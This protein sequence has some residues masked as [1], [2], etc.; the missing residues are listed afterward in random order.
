M[1]EL[2]RFR[3]AR[4]PQKIGTEPTS[5]IEIGQDSP[6]NTWL[7]ADDLPTVANGYLTQNDLAPPATTLTINNEPEISTILGK[8]RTLDQFLSQHSNRPTVTA[9][10]SELAKLKLDEGLRYQLPNEITS[11]YDENEFKNAV[12][13]DL[14]TIN[15]NDKYN[16]LKPNQLVK[17]TH[18]SSEVIFGSPEAEDTTSVLWL[19]D[20]IS[21]NNLQVPHYLEGVF[22]APV[23]AFCLWLKDEGEGTSS[24]K[25]EVYD[26]SDTLISTLSTQ[27]IHLWDFEPSTSQ[28][29]SFLG[30]LSRK[31]IKSFIIKSGFSLKLNSNGKI[32]ELSPLVPNR[33]FVD[34]FR[35]NKPIPIT[36]NFFDEMR[37]RLGTALVA[38]VLGNATPELRVDLTRLMLVVGLI[39]LSS[40]T[41]LA[42]PDDIYWA[43]RWRSII[44][45]K[46]FL[47]KVRSQRSILARRAGFSDLYIVRDEWN[48][49]EAGEIA[50]IENV[51]AKESKERK[52]VRVD[53][54]EEMFVTDTEKSTLNELDSQTTNRFELSDEA[55]QDVSLAAHIEGKV[56]TSGQYG[57]THV[58]TQLGG[59]LDY[60]TEQSEK[61]ATKLAQETIA[62]AVTRVEEK[63]RETRSRRTLTRIEETNTHSLKNDTD[64]HI[65]G[66]Y[67]WVDKIQR[68]QIFRYPNRYLLEFEVP[69]PGAWIRWLIKINKNKGLLNQEP[70]PFNL[71][72]TQGKLLK[73]SD[74]KVENYLE[75][76]ARYGTLGLTPPPSDEVVSTGFTKASL[77]DNANYKKIPNIGFETINTMTVST[78]YEAKTWEAFIHSWQHD[79]ALGPGGGGSVRISVGTGELKEKAIGVITDENNGSIDKIISGD[80]G[81]I[82]RGV[83]PVSLMTDSIYGFS[84]NVN[85]TCTPLVQTMDKW[86]IDNY[87]KIVSTFNELKLRYDE[88]VAAKSVREGILISGDSSARNKEIIHEELKKQ[89]IEMLIGLDFK[90]RNALSVK[91]NNGNPI[92]PE[93]QLKEAKK[94]APEIQF[95]EQA[96]E[97]ENL[98]YVLYPY[99]W[100]DH[101]RWS[102]LADIN[103]ADPEFVRFL[104]SGSV[105]VIL[106]ARP[107]FEAQ[108]QIYTDFG[109]LWGGGPVPAPGEEGY[110]S[111]A[112]EIKAQTQPP[113]DGIPGESWEVRLPTSLIWLENPVGLPKNPAPKLSPPFGENKGCICYIIKPGDTLS[114]I[115]LRFYGN[116]EEYMKIFEANRDVIGDDPD[117]IYAGQVITIPR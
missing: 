64:R 74:L 10:K 60:S 41:K 31:P 66:V 91:D 9:L 7:L 47:E 96:F 37:R 92:E 98:T 38:A 55:S 48:R 87:E 23:H 84:L 94:F 54:T 71:D 5:V 72:G 110:L 85:V 30:I 97:W 104:R 51:L 25:I 67:Q 73:A 65:V 95:L 80:V 109:I 17:G 4:A 26:A 45:P 39:D 75:I 117:K 63:V 88:E 68:M 53:E 19:N 12:G 90:G 52:H 43:L 61:R 35:A 2:M 40:S 32:E 27:P 18:F 56:D 20:A 59:S 83:V 57:P 77:D 86:K 101:D 21:N 108:V 107:G 93:I 14:F 29:S 79:C 78:G 33:F 100:A 105:R 69:E 70:I 3:V 1:S 89:V 103:G 22:Q 76:G 113:K 114:A 111:V 62:R 6:L 49:Y 81:G 106:P 82:T 36:V 13:E 11:Y 102:A 28:N 16:Q 50:H 99:Y 44:F 8:I 34:D 115:A 112:E 24:A 42:M 15:F 116:A 46:C 58:D